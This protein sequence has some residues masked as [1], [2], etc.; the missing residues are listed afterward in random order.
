[1]DTFVSTFF[2]ASHSAY[3]LVDT[4]A[5]HSYMSEEFRSA[6]ALKKKLFQK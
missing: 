1:M 5:M 3:A 6:C 2:I 4:S